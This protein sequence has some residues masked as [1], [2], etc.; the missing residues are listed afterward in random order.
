MKII[1]AM[2]LGTAIIALVGLLMARGQRWGLLGVASAEGNTA[3]AVRIDANPSGNTATSLGTVQTCRRVATGENF[4][5]DVVIE[6]VTNLLGFD[7]AFAYDATRLKVVDRDIEFLLASAPG[8]DLLDTSDSAPDS[9]GFYGLRALD[10]SPAPPAAE[11]GSG[12]LGRVTLQATNPG[13]STIFVSVPRISPRLT[14]VD[15]DPL[16]PADEFGV[17]LGDVFAARI[18]ID[19]ECP[20]GETGP[21]PTPPIPTVLPQTPT[22]QGNQVTPATSPAT[23]PT[24][25]PTGTPAATVTPV[26]GGEEGNGRDLTAVW[27]IGGAVGGILA[28]AAAYAAWRLLRGR[29]L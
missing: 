2:L 18:A 27:V 13:L 16:E 25:T 12:V 15:R 10:R 23:T 9:D 17:W 26:A 29:P 22:P 14:D 8:S 4:E 6:N 24:G 7:T 20:G 19:E 28:L 5:V 11:S 21:P 1:S 3:D